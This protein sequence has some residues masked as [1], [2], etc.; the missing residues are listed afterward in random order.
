MAVS[1]VFPGVPEAPSATAGAGDWSGAVWLAAEAGAAGRSA[2]PGVV[3]D[4]V[5]AARAL[6]SADCM[7]STC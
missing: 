6:F 4:L 2:P 7:D 1:P 5:V 3:T